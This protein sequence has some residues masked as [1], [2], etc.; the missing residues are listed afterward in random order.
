M[1]KLELGSGYHP[2]PGFLTLDL[3]PKTKPDFIGSAFPLPQDA[4]THA[5]EDGPF[6]EL[7]AVDVLEHLSYRHTVPA[8]AGWR[9]IVSPGARLYIQVP[10]AAQIMTW[11]HHRDNRLLERLPVE[12]PQTHL[13]GAAWRLLGGH[14]DGELVEFGGDFRLNAHF[15]L[16]D[17]P[18]LNTQLEESGWEVESM[19]VNG[20]P[21]IC[22]WA[23]AV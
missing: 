13:A 12:L 2:T 16:F 7:R 14:A 5:R 9:L 19:T 22:C 6:E 10:D 23:V 17:R 1:A 15:A 4:H 3:N 20:H 18:S 21:N 8:L 11:W